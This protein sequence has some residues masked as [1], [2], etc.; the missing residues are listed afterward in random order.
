MKNL[1][2]II[3]AILIGFSMPAFSQTVNAKYIEKLENTIGSL[4]QQIE[5]TD[6]EKKKFELVTRLNELYDAYYHPQVRLYHI[7]KEYPKF[8]AK[9][10][11]A[12]KFSEEQKRS[13]L[14][15]GYERKKNLS[16]IATLTGVL[17]SPWPILNQQEKISACNDAVDICLNER[18]IKH[19]RFVVDRCKPYIK[20]ETYKEITIK[21]KVFNEQ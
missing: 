3:A 20:E 21:V 16:D 7:Q 12:N 10:I 6:D 17:N 5:R 2:K 18:D 14:D 19:C 8:A 11:Q 15:A 9:I 4:R 1:P 13:I